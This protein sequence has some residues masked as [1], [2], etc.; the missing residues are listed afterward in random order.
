DRLDVGFLAGPRSR[1]RIE[2]RARD[3]EVCGEAVALGLDAALGRR[4]HVEVAVVGPSD[5]V[6]VMPEVTQLVE[7]REDLPSPRGAVVDDD[8][9]RDVVRQAEPRDGGLLEGPL[10]HEDPG[11]LDAIAPSLERV[12]SAGEGLLLGQ[13]DAEDAAQTG[14]IEGPPR[15]EQEAWTGRVSPS[16]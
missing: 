6:V 16:G 10:E 7:Q 4:E 11:A 9:G 2:A 12:L 14:G 3:E 15:G 1:E 8:D 13:R 5:P